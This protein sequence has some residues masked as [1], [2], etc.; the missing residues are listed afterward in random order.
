MAIPDFQSIMLPLLKHLADGKEHSSQDIYEAMEK[1]FSL[2]REEREE[3]LPSG[4]QRVFVNRIGWAKSYLKLSELIASTQR[5][6]YKIT[7][8]GLHVLEDK[9]LSH[10][11]V[12]FLFSVSDLFAKRYGKQRIQAAQRDTNLVNGISAHSRTPEEN[13]EVGLSAID[14]ALTQELLIKIRSASPRFFEKVVL[15]LLLKMGYGGS[16]QDAGTLTGKGSD[17]GID[18]I[19]N[20]DRL[21]L[22]SIHIQAKRWNNTVT[23][24]EIQKFA[25]ALQGKR[26]RKGIYITTSSFTKE[27]YA[28]IDAIDSTIVLIDGERLAKLMIEYGVGVSTVQTFS[29]YRI[30]SDFFIE[31]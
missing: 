15:E 2:S 27:A 11:D 24:P 13:I 19:I 21:G 20:E 14:N 28:F 8:N 9:D 25:G 23:R 5:G 18:G 30:D 7:N 16:R 26:A 22:D 29:I 3:L 6:F 31:E 17:E 12:K 4:K 10:I 1:T